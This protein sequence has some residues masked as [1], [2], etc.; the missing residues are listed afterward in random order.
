M[1]KVHECMCFTTYIRPCSR[2]LV[3]LHAVYIILCESVYTARIYCTS[4]CM[5]YTQMGNVWRS[6]MVAASIVHVYR[7]IHVAYLHSFCSIPLPPTLAAKFKCNP[8][9]APPSVGVVSSML[10]MLMYSGTPLRQTA[11]GQAVSLAPGS[12]ARKLKKEKRRKSLVRFDH[13]QDVVGRGLKIAVDFAHAR[14][15]VL[16]EQ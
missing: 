15:L 8:A 14:A 12:P 9:A 5:W 10:L 13:M 3:G 7:D 1:H 16:T 11:T 2:E 4:T 6:G